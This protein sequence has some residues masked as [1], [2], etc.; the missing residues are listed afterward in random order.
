LVETGPHGYADLAGA[1]GVK[2]AADWAEGNDEVARAYAEAAKRAE[3]QKRSAH[4][5]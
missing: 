3:Q 4:A 1:A 5:Q 2:A